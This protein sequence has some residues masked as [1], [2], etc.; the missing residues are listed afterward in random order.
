[1][2]ITMGKRW[3]R[4]AI[5]AAI[6]TG[7]AAGARL[8][9]NLRF[10]NL[11]NLKSLDT[12]FVLRGGLG[13]SNI[14]LVTADQKALDTFPELRIFWHPYYAAA[15]RA[16][17]EGGARLIGLD[18]AFGVPV[19]KWEPDYDR[20]LGEAVIA[21]PVP[22]VCG[23]VESFNG[24]QEAQSVPV[25]LLSAAMGLSGFSNLYADPDDFVRRQELIEAPS[26]NP[27]DPPPAR[28]FALRI[29]EKYLGSE[30]EFRNGKLMLAGQAIPISA[31]RSILIRDAAPPETVP[32]V[33]LVDVV[34]A[35]RGGEIAQL[36]DRFKGKIVLIGSDF[37]G[38]SD[39]GATP[40]YT[41]FSGPRW[42][43]SGVEIQANTIRT[44]LDRKYLLD[45]PEWARDGVL[46]AS[47]LTAAGIV[48]SLAAGPAEAW[49]ALEILTIFVLSHLL[50]RAGLILSTSETVVA[51]L[52]CVLLSIAYRLLTSEKR[53]ALFRRAISLFVGKEL[54]RSLDDAAAI[55]LSGRRVNVT[56]LFTDIR[57]FTAFTEQ[58]CDEQ[59]PET[60]V[61]LL[62]DYLASMVSI[63]V[64][65]RGHV[66][67]FLGDGIL[68]VFSDDDEG[69][70]PG[71]HALRA[72][73]C[74]A[75]IVTVPSRF[76][77][78]AGIHTG[79]A[80]VG[81]V[82]SADKMEYTVL[83]DTVNLASRLES[84]NKEHKT[85]LLMS[86]A[87]RSMLGDT[88]GTTHLGAIPVRGK[89]APIDL[90]TVTSLV[91]SS[92]ALVNA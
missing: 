50:F 85:K 80:V 72:V 2:Q 84:L 14:V 87:T 90:Y 11:L 65:H 64:K 59:G 82:G 16:A 51:T 91:E 54:A 15:I 57:G 79:P 33:S 24:N 35:E 68:A 37:T 20:L 32:S 10:F 75:E 36:R 86:E 18:V 70:S 52:F 22:V 40:F 9:S 27:L 89:A 13:S 6:A 83:G 1:M 19:A 61:D 60:V 76:Q 53:G 63:I 28:S 41:L 77:T 4:W 43:T 47:T 55:R 39:R 3:Q 17:G 30:A 78:G 45:L 81:N 49:V 31:D 8:L 5:C 66:N 7:S 21:S 69:T 92:K 44:L 46:L 62:N 71:S 67:K 12:H 73:L 56:I 34:A 88:I 29:A 26:Q 23:F 48:T 58:T 74:A 42:T 25:N 38:D